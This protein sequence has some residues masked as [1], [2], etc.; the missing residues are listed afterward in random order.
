[1]IENLKLGSLPDNFRQ[2]IKQYCIIQIEDTRIGFNNLHKVIIFTIF[3]KLQGH[4]TY[5]ETGIGLLIAKKVVE[6][7]RGYITTSSFET[8]GITFHIVLPKSVIIN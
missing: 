5:K 4:Q 7:H 8:E 2:E 6:N 3:Q 1:V